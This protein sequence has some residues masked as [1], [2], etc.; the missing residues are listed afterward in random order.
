MK[1]KLSDR[2]EGCEGGNQKSPSYHLL[3]PP[4]ILRASFTQCQP[5]LEPGQ[6]RPDPADAIL[7]WSTVA[8]VCNSSSLSDTVQVCPLWPRLPGDCVNSPANLRKYPVGV[9][10]TAAFTTVPVFNLQRTSKISLWVLQPGLKAD[11]RTTWKKWTF[12][13]YLKMWH[14]DN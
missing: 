1:K 6:S 7:V 2:K 10:V 3:A 14:D 12:I 4:H 5:P 13:L 8:A 9:F 11:C